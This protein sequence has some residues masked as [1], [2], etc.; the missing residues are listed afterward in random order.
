MLLANIP[1]LNERTEQQLVGSQVEYEGLGRVRNGVAYR[2]GI[3]A[4]TAHVVLFLGK[5]QSRVG[6]CTED[7]ARSAPRT[8]KYLTTNTETNGAFAP[9]K[10]L[11]LQ[12]IGVLYLV[13]HLRIYYSKAYDSSQDSTTLFAKNIKNNEFTRKVKSHNFNTVVSKVT[14]NIQSRSDQSLAFD[15]TCFTI[16]SAKPDRQGDAHPWTH[17]QTARESASLLGSPRFG[18]S[19]WRARLSDL[20]PITR[21]VGSAIHAQRSPIRVPSDSTFGVTLLSS[22]LRIFFV[23]EKMYEHTNA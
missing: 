19:A 9:G 5:G 14:L 15:F 6:A 23:K 3:L 2:A 13:F 22:S 8:Q 4:L 11:W 17:N 10:N 16:I 12:D 1:T 7:G 18:D 21:H 20:W